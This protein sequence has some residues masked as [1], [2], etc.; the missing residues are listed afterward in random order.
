M[1]E[2][3]KSIQTPEGYRQ[4]N[5]VIEQLTEL[6]NIKFEYNQLKLLIKNLNDPIKKL[7]EKQSEYTGLIGTEDADIITALTEELKVAAKNVKIQ[8]LEIIKIAKNIVLEVFKK[9]RNEINEEER[10]GEEGKEEFLTRGIVRIKIDLLKIYLLIQDKNP[11]IPEKIEDILFE[12]QIR[13]INARKKI[14]NS[15]EPEKE[16]LRLLIAYLNLA[17]TEAKKIENYIDKLFAPADEVEALPPRRLLEEPELVGQQAGGGLEDEKYKSK[18]ID[19][20]HT[21]ELYYSKNTDNLIIELLKILK[22]LQKN[23]KKFKIY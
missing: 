1:Q 9:K 2:N 7:L 6:A 14:I 20:K 5:K 21:Y 15:N 8:V 4:L 12:L 11:N 19:I 10:K 23:Y 17:I 13:L 22:M 16:F 18:N 3:E